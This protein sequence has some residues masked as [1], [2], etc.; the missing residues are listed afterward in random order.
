MFVQD[1]R[2]SNDAGVNGLFGQA[3]SLIGPTSNEIGKLLGSL[4][5]R[6]GARSKRGLLDD[7][8][9]TKPDAAGLLTSLSSAADVKTVLDSA[10]LEADEERVT[11]LLGE[12]GGKDI[13]DL[14]EDASS[15]V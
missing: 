13:E 1:D 15:T 2:G 11:S 5:D 14:I 6:V 10:G 4:E 7:L 9:K 12:L 3:G 8:L